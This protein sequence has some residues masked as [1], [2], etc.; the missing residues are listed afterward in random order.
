MHACGVNFVIFVTICGLIVGCKEDNPKSRPGWMYHDCASI[1][2]CVCAVHMHVYAF[3]LRR[4]CLCDVS[5]GGA[6]C[7]CV[8][9]CTV[10]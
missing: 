4:V 7:V 9:T 8:C 6:V 5:L 1:S 2:V 10:V 3:A